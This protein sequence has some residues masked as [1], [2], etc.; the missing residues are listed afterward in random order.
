MKRVFVNLAVNALEAIEGH[1]EL[2]I[3]TYVEEGRIN[4][5]SEP[6]Q[7]VVVEFKDDGVGIPAENL[8][9]VLE[10]FYSTKGSGTGLGL[11]IAQRVVERHNGKIS[12]ESRPNK[13]T[14]VRV[15]IPHFVADKIN[16]TCLT[17]KAA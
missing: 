6:C 3:S 4:G 5:R 8:N 10:P 12:I 13:G 2:T 9:R 1:G 11:S 14:K 15:H 17:R 7:F 16:T